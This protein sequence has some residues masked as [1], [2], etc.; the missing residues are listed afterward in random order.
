M[1]HADAVS[2]LATERYL[3]GD[4]TDAER[5]AFEAHFFDCT[6]CAADVRAAAT[7]ADGA[8]LGLIEAP[9]VRP[10][11]SPRAASTWRQS[12]ILPWAIAA[13]LAVV[14]VYQAWPTSSSF[15]SLPSAL[16]LAP[17][18]L[19]PASRGEDASIDVAPGSPGIALAIDLTSAPTGTLEYDLRTADGRDVAAGQVPAPP[20]GQPLLLLVPARLLTPSTRYILA[21]RNSVNPGLTTAEYRFT[22][23]AR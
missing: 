9:R 19:R 3:L 18:T 13:T 5:D 2:T 4:M 11:V 8:R 23:V 1:T 12:A 10:F 16:A 14:V 15:T 7:M 20:S 6:E 17:I 22:V 21:I